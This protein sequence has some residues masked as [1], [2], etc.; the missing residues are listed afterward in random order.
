MP[1]IVDPSAPQVTVPATV[2]SPDG[3]LSA[4]VDSAW[5]GVYL[6]VN[7]AAPAAGAPYAGAA[8]VRQV[9]VTR[10]DPRAAAPVPVRSAD[11]AWAVAGT[12]RAYDHEAPLGVAVVYAATPLLADGTEGPT[13]AVAVTV[14]APVGWSDVW[15]KS[16]D[17]P[18]TSVLAHVVEWPTLAWSSRTDTAAVLGSPY[19]VAALDAFAASTSTMRINVEP[20]DIPGFKALV[21]T[22]QVLLVQTLPEYN[23]PDQYAILGDLSEDA[24]ATPEQGRI[25]TVAVTEVNRPDTAGQPLRLP[26]WSWDAL[27]AQFATWDAVAA[28]YSSWASLSI[29]GAL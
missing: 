20:D 17:T 29:N 8:D 14:P 27:A 28:S 6:A 15:I 9:R 11:R 21:L 26:A 2:T 23:R 10:Q 1:M 19:P 18:G 4:A 13:S 3:W 5:A 12:G 25:Y 22:P 16:L 24:D 7:Y